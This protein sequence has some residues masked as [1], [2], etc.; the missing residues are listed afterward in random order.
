M[1][2]PLHKFEEAGRCCF[3]PPQR[4]ERLLFRP[5]PLVGPLP[6]RMSKFPAQPLKARKANQRGAA[7]LSK[8]T[9]GV[10]PFQTALLAKRLIC[11][12]ERAHLRICNAV[13]VDDV[14]HSKAFDLF[15]QPCS[16]EAGKFRNCLNVDVQR[17]EKKSAVWGVGTGIRGLVIKQ[18]MQRIEPDARSA[19]ISSEV[20]ERGKIGKVAMPP[21][22]QRPHPV[23]LHTERP[24]PPRRRLLPLIRPVPTNN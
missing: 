2:Y 9:E 11:K 16:L 6:P 8:P 5:S 4:I 7:R 18:S 13:I 24:H 23:E 20:D 10:T 21:I 12:P 15:F 3:G 1:G 19:Q 17:T 22:A 14:L